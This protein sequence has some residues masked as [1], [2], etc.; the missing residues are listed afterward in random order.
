M[1]KRLCTFEHFWF[2]TL[3]FISVFIY[4]KGMTDSYI[5]PKWCFTSLILLLGII[6]LSVKRMCGGALNWDILVCSNI[7]SSVCVFQL[8]YG[9]AQ[10]LQLFSS[11][12]R[13][14]MGSFDN[15]AGFSAC[16]CAGFPFILFS[17]KTIK[18][19][20][21][22]VVMGGMTFITIWA[23]FLSA[24]RAGII[25]IIVII[26]VVL[27][28]QIRI[29]EK[30]KIVLFIC[31]L[32][33]LLVG[34]YFFKKDSADGR[35]LIWKCSWEMIKESPV[36]GCGTGTFRRYYMDYQSEYFRMYPNSRFAVLADNVQCPFNEYL[37]II[38]NFGFWG[39]F[40]LLV[41]ISI[42]LCCYRKNP[43]IEKKVALLSV[44]AIGIFSVFSYPFTY[45]FIWIITFF[46]ICIIVK[47]TFRLRMSA[48]YEKT[49]CSITIIA[50]MLSLSHLYQR[51]KAEY[52][53]CEASYMH[54]IVDYEELF[55]ILGK[56]PYFLY[57]YAVVLYDMNHLERSR[58]VALLCRKEWADYDL[59]L[60]LGDIYM[61]E[62][63]YTLAESSYKKASFM[64]PCRFIPLYKLFCLY[65]NIGCHDKAYV[66]AQEINIK[67][68]KIPSIAVRQ[69]KCKIKRY[70]Q[71]LDGC[72][73]YE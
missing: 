33:L 62:K 17:F 51:I 4:S 29:D 25:G 32:S 44:L 30:S 28:K 31:L 50:C 11:D 18:S 67:S 3:C 68:E 56:D 41:I 9:I 15:P 55:S 5:V 19:R 69:I 60:L 21:L 13:W 22:K 57:N 40:A 42:L 8:L 39:I 10:W 43:S 36:L 63:E 6:V 46:C 52:Q 73:E 49:L 45:P 64:C 34:S 47:G 14:V 16:L 58:N 27:Y 12:S 53:W 66:V 7:I 65:K 38:L 35:L 59:E 48:F 2:L 61:R 1:I 70:T 71:K 37:S 23:L 72:K 20:K 26:C 24:S 54:N